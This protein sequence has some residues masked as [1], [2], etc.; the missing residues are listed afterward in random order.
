[1]KIGNE[2]DPSK[3]RA[4]DFE[5]LA[6]EANLNPKAAMRRMFALLKKTEQLLNDRPALSVQAQVVRCIRKNMAW[7]RACLPTA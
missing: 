2:R 1:M 5:A 7:M 6:R 3:I 4:G